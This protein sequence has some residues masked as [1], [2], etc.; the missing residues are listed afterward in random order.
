MDRVARQADGWFLTYPT[1]DQ[2][3]LAGRHLDQALALA[4]RP[5]T[6]VTRAALFRCC[7]S[8]SPDVLEQAAGRLAAHDLALEALVAGRAA[9]LEGAL[10]GSRAEV[11]A[12]N[13][14]LIGQPHAIAERLDGYRAA[15]MEHAVIAFVPVA[16]S[17]RSLEVF[18]K[19]VMPT[20]RD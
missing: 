20:L 19:Q 3:R 6:A 2:Y 16:D 7:I 15:G 9:E 5:P 1:V 4:G 12:R 8:E 10:T 18:A 17:S 13:R 14:H 11:A